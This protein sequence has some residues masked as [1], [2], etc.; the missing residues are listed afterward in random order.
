MLSLK[1][2]QGTGVQIATDLSIVSAC[3]TLVD[4]VNVT[5]GGV[6]YMHSPIDDSQLEYR[7]YAYDEMD[8]ELR[9][10]SMIQTT[11][12]REETPANYAPATKPTL[13]LRTFF[14]E[15]W[16]FDLQDSDDGIIDR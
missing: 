3:E 6:N 8:D 1:V 16:L 12:I 9:S 5:H 10:S 14:P 4:A 7:D 2:Y 11:S 15:N 13:Q